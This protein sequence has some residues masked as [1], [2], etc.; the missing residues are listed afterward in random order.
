M[1]HATER[2]NRYRHRALALAGDD[3]EAKILALVELWDAARE[4]AEEERGFR[5]YVELQIRD[6]LG[7]A[8][9]VVDS[10]DKGGSDANGA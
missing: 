4:Y 7:L 6:K 9:V 2:Y 1:S 8:P 10:Q 3:D 5:R